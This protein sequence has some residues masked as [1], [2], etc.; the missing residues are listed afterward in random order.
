[1][2]YHTAVKKNE[3]LYTAGMAVTHML[4]KEARHKGI[5]AT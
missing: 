4:S 2:E 1:M 3:L 5:Y